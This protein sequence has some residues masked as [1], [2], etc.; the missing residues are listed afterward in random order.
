M[1]VVISADGG[2]GGGGGGGGCTSN[3]FL[4]F[5]HFTLNTPP[6]SP[7]VISEYLGV[8]GGPWQDCLKLETSARSAM[9]DNE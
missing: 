6:L 1:F 2:G 7:Q 9:I 5:T 3:C 8:N 4:G